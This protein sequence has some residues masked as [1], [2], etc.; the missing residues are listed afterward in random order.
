[1]M[2][3]G[4]PS[5]DGEPPTC[6]GRGVAMPLVEFRA[7]SRARIRVTLSLEQ[8][9]SPNAEASAERTRFAG[10]GASSEGPDRVSKR[11]SANPMALALTRSGGAGPSE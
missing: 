6:R 2:P 3:A 9:T 8:A 11:L 4:R 10:R 1:M 7:A 5:M